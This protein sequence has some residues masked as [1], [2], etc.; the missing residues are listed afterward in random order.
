M[1]DHIRP[2]QYV[3]DRVRFTHEA[4]EFTGRGLLT[5][6]PEKG[7]HIEAFL[8]QTLPKGILMPPFPLV[9]LNDTTD[10]RC[11]R[12]AGREFGHAVVPNVFPLDLS[13]NLHEGR[14]SIRPQRIIFFQHVPAIGTGAREHEHWSGSAVILTKKDPEFPDILKTETTLNGQTIHSESRGGLSLDEQNGFSVWGWKT[15]ADSFT[16][17][18]A[19][20]KST[21]SRTV[22]WQ[23]AEAA[24][25]ALSILF[26][27]TAWIVRVFASRGTTEITELRPRKTVQALSHFLQPI[28]DF[29]P[30]GQ[31]KFN[32][33]AFIQLTRYFANRDQ[34]AEVCWSIFRR[35]AEAS[36]QE[37]WQSRELLVA[38]TLD[39]ALR[40]LDNHPF[41]SGDDSWKILQSFE[42]FCQTYFGTGWEDAC[43]RALE[44]RKRLR[45]RNAHPE[46]I[47]Y[48]EGSLSK[49]EWCQSIEDLTFL[50]R[51]YGYMILAL[52][53]F[54]T[55]QPKFLPV[56]FK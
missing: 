25:R 56:P 48:P 20:P 51:F 50:S 33:T 3:L 9:R 5:W 29:G 35:L 1:I 21:S 44:V 16:L 42:R 30:P 39:A 37:T 8:E 45:H 11:I 12:L 43:K 6:D 52:A 49:P 2:A 47:T 34:Q 32:K 7:I 31:R 10:A 28:T 55:L 15:G 14:V 4:K 22:A 40:T 13:E 38:T 19:L 54:K 18:W 36:R 41:K 17:S 23:W 27:Q 24:R 53:G 26:A 46:W